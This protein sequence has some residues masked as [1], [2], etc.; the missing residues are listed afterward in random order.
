[1]IDSGGPQASVRTIPFAKLSFTTC[2]AVTVDIPRDGVCC[3][4]LSLTMR[5]P[6]QPTISVVRPAMSNSTGLRSLMSSSD[7]AAPSDACLQAIFLRSPLTL[8]VVFDS[9]D[10][11]SRAF[12]AQDQITWHGDP[13]GQQHTPISATECALP[14]SIF[15]SPPALYQQAA[16]YLSGVPRALGSSRFHS[17]SRVLTAAQHVVL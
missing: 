2:R 4:E 15:H 13:Q 17:L 3:N 5:V 11:R 6:L 12:D 8:L 16:L 1:M 10:N 14:L 7:T 9:S